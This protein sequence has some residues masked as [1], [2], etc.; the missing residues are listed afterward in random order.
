MS[1]LPDAALWE[2]T[3][4]GDQAT[5]SFSSRDETGTHFWASFES[6]TSCPSG[7]FLDL[8]IQRCRPDLTI[9]RVNDGIRAA[10]YATSAFG[11]LFVLVCSVVVLFFWDHSIIRAASRPFLLLLRPPG[12]AGALPSRPR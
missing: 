4:F 9:H 8:G 1:L 6:A 12:H 5:V 11:M 3:V 7:Y 10:V 2:V